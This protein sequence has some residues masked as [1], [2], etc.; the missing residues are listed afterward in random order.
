MIKKILQGRYTLAHIRSRKKARR[1]AIAAA[2]AL[3]QHKPGH[4]YRDDRH[5]TAARC[6]RHL[7]KVFGHRAEQVQ[8]AIM[9]QVLA[10]RTKR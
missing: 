3:V 10:G 4:P 2:E 1:N 6:L 8:H 5:R 9:R 7:N